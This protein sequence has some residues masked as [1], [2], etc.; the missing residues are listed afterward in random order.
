VV[1]NTYGKGKSVLIP[2]QLGAQYLFK[3]HYMH[4][5]L[6]V[7]ALQ[8]VLTVEKTVIT[9]ASPLIE[10]S[11]LANRNGAYEWLGMINH[12]GQL[13]G[14]LREP[15]TIHNTNIRFRPVKP[16]KQLKLMRAGTT[17][18]FK[19]ANGWVEARV[20]RLNDFEMLLCLY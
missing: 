6:F 20:P 19:Q 4:R 5:A 1:T 13:G 14:S 9:D 16:I 10:I 7:A 3:G 12:S 8:N 18:D 15:V 17:I 2:W 11:H